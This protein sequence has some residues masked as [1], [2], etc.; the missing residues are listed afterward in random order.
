MWANWETVALAEWLRGIMKGKRRMKLM[1]LDVYSLWESFDE[2]LKY[3]ENKDLTIK[4]AA[5]DAFNC[6]EPYKRGEGQE[7]AL[8][9]SGFVVLRR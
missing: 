6:F 9:M 2:V 8:A 3:L 1:V 5:L 4:K 7:Y